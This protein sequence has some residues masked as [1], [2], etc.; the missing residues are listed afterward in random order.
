MSWKFIP[1]QVPIIISGVVITVISVSS[2]TTSPVWFEDILRQTCRDFA[3]GRTTVQRE[4]NSLLADQVGFGVGVPHF[5]G[6]D[7]VKGAIRVPQPDPIWTDRG[8][9]RKNLVRWQEVT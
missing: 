6:V 7:G 2:L 3:Q 5:A 8:R 9:Q 4:G 1:Y